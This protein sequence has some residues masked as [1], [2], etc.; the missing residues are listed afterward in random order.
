[1]NYANDEIAYQADQ[2]KWDNIK[3]IC[4]SDLLDFH[5]D[6]Q[7]RHVKSITKLEVACHALSEYEAGHTALFLKCLAS[8][9]I[10]NFSFMDEIS[11]MNRRTIEGVQPRQGHAVDASGVEYLLKSISQISRSLEKIEC[12]VMGRTPQT[13]E[14]CCRSIQFLSEM[15]Q[16]GYDFP[17]TYVTRILVDCTK[18]LGKSAATSPWIH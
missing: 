14:E 18:V 17:S 12:E 6:M 1:M 5:A 15:M 4:L 13:R 9:S 2:D 11:A 16:D 7:E 8:A 10:E 3:A